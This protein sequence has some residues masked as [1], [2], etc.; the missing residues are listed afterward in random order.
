[1]G[2][3][4][5]LRLPGCPRRVE[6]RGVV[7]GRSSTSGA[8]RRPPAH[9]RSRKETMCVTAGGPPGRPGRRGGRGPHRRRR[10]HAGPA[11]R[12][13]GR[14]RS[15]RSSS[16]KTT[17]LAESDRPNS[18]SLA[19]HQAL[20]GTTTRRR[21]SHPK[22]HHP[23]GKVAHRNGHPITLLDAVLVPEAVGDGRGDPVVLPEGGPLVLVDQKVAVTAGEGQVEDDA[24]RG[25]GVFP[26]SQRHAVDLDVFHLEHLPRPGEGGGGLPD[27]HGR[28]VVAHPWS[29]P[30]GWSAPRPARRLGRL[31]VG[32][33]PT[34]PRS[35]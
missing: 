16:A 31:H 33:R 27:G 29:S 15:R 9:R 12:Q 26:G 5:P 4:G 14:I 22:G 19:V 17:T 25:G 13:V 30:V 35:L 21:G 28:G 7:L 1:M 6:D 24:Q 10:P 23:L 34:R 11:V 18:S 20:R 32:S 8:R 2:T 3:D